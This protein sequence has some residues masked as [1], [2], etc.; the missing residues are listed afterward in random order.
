MCVFTVQPQHLGVDRGDT[1]AQTLPFCASPLSDQTY[2]FALKNTEL[3]DEW[4]IPPVACGRQLLEFADG[5]W[6]QRLLPVF[7]RTG[8]LLVPHFYRSLVNALVELNVVAM[9]F[10][11]VALDEDGFY[12]RSGT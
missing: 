11:D 12:S 6:E 1:K 2:A 3:R 4:S 8:N 7:D 9:H 5:L 10:R